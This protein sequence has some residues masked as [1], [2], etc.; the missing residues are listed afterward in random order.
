MGG[1]VSK[2]VTHRPA[3]RPEAAGPP[4]SCS[5]VDLAEF[6]RSIVEIGLIDAEEL[7]RFVVTP[8]EVLTSGRCL[9]TRS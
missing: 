5:V 8:N 6:Q 7:A 1:G 2:T 9:D 3:A 4:D